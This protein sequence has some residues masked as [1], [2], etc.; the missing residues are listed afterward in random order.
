MKPIQ[1]LE[2]LSETTGN[3]ESPG[4][5]WELCIPGVRLPWTAAA[6]EF[7]VLCSQRHPTCCRDAEQEE[8]T[9]GQ[10]Q[11]TTS[12]NAAGRGGEGCELNGLWSLAKQRST[13]CGWFSTN[14]ILMQ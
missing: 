7:S 5:C 11:G 14:F 9:Q 13:L 6:A 4:C 8:K 10:P 3:S 1:G 12:M 2:E